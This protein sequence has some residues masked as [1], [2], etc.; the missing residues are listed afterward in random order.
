MFLST[1]Y[2]GWSVSGFRTIAISLENQICL[3]KNQNIKA[4]LEMLI[5]F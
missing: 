5:D 4:K 1:V 3:N 2:L